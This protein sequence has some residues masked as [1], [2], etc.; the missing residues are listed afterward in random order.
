[1]CIRLRACQSVLLLR[2]ANT[3]KLP[4]RLQIAPRQPLQAG[5]FVCLQVQTDGVTHA[6]SAH[7]LKHA[8]RRRIGIMLESAA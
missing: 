2:L 4:V 5:L 7:D 6:P 8:V 3:D 1:M